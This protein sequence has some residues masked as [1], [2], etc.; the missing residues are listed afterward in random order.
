MSAEGA[1]ISKCYPRTWEEPMQRASIIAVVILIAASFSLHAQDADR[2][3]SGVSPVSGQPSSPQITDSAP[4]RARCDARLI[5]TAMPDYPKEAQREKVTG[6]VALKAIIA[7]DGMLKNVTPLSGH[8]LLLE[9]AIRAVS[10]WRY[11][12]CR[13]NGEP[14]E[15]P[16]RIRITFG[17]TAT[18]EPQFSANSANDLVESAPVEPATQSS[19]ASND[20]ATE[21][22]YNISD[23]EITPPV[24]TYGPDPTYTDDARRANIQGTVVLDCIIT[25]LGKTRDISVYESLDP[26]LDQQAIEAVRGWKFDPAIKDGQPVSVKLRVTVTFRLYKRFR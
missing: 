5:Y 26:G 24:L 25:S 6:E 7:K 14:V 23:E 22:I 19:R 8:P 9:A 12:P 17:L 10:K 2:T 11:E 16:T 21:P 3:N 4:T 13:L 18:G 1:V 20:E 15:V